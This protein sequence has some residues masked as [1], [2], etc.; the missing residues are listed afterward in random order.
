[1]RAERCRG[2][3]RFGARCSAA[4]TWGGLRRR[5]QPGCLREGG[6]PS[7]SGGSEGGGEETSS[8]AGEARG[9]FR[10]GEGET[11]SALGIMGLILAG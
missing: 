2:K 9:L 11:S 8:L 3:G 4:G 6:P 7:D 10:G 1:M 5:A